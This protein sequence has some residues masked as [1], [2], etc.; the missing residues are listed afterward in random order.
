MSMLSVLNA[1]LHD[2]LICIM[3]CEIRTNHRKFEVALRKEDKK[4]RVF[5]HFYAP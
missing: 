3:K 5:L 4:C 1:N 2:Y